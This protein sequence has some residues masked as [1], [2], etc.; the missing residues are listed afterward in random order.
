MRE[1]IISIYVILVLFAVIWN[2]RIAYWID[3]RSLRKRLKET[4]NG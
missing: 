3:I 1:I 4:K 2:Y